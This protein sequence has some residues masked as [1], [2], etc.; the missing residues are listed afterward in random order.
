MLLEHDHAR[1]GALRHVV[2]TRSHIEHG[3][4]GDATEVLCDELVH[5]FL[6]DSDRLGADL[7]VIADHDSLASDTEKGQ[8][9]DVALGALIDDHDIEWLVGGVEGLHRPVSGHDPDGH[10]SPRLLHRLLC[11][12]APAWRV[13]AGSFADLLQCLRPF[14]ERASLGVG[15]LLAHRQ[16]GRSRS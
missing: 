10:S 9:E 1:E 8:G 11:L 3:G 13:L 6:I 4:V 7:L 2:Q 16:P 14:G 5:G 12:G 15:E